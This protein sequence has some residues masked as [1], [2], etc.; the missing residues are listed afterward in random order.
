MDLKTL[1]GFGE[2]KKELKFD[3]FWDWFVAYNDVHTLWRAQPTHL[4]VSTLFL[5][6]G[7]LTFYHDVV[8]IYTAAIFVDKLRLPTWSEPFA[9]GL[10]VVLIDYPYDL[11]AVKFVHWTWHDTDPNIFDRHYHIPWNSFYFHATFAAAFIFWF[12]FVRRF[13]ISSKDRWMPGSFLKESLCTLL[14]SL[15]GMPTGVI[16]FIPNY[17]LLHDIYNLHSEVTFYL[18]LAA[19][20][21]LILRGILSLKTLPQHTRSLK[22]YLL[23]NY[24][25]IYY[26]IFFGMALIG[27][28]SSEVSIGLHEP[29]GPCEE[30]VAIKTAFGQTLYKRK[31]LCVTDYDESYFNF[32]CLPNGKP[33]GKIGEYYTICGT[34]FEN[35]VEYIILMLTITIIAAG[36]FL[37]IF[38]CTTVCKNTLKKKN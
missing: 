38:Y 34:P 8:F 24:L 3:G 27:D 9:V 20:V 14:A 16:L 28:P 32:S 36:V 37:N 10:I 26:L 35:R 6:G 22:D 4:I 15:L 33:S 19:F 2:I 21:A 18:L 13:L 5:V 29:I 25:V 23:L 30:K 11:M 12:H 31:Y 1:S 7:L 17:H